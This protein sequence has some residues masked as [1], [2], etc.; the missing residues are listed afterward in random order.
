MAAESTLPTGT[1]KLD[2]SETTITV[3][4]KKLGMFTVPATLQMT[5]GALEIDDNHQVVNVDIVADAA[6]YASKSG[7]RNEHVVGSDFLDADAHP[8]LAFTASAVTP[9]TNG[10]RTSGSVTVK[11]QSSPVDV[12][13]DN[14]EITD[15]Q[16]S[17]TATAT[18]DR[19]AVGVDKM[20]TMMI[21]R[22]LQIMVSANA[23]RQG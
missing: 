22:D 5:S 3:S 2:P 10:Y 13:I 1:W 20:P 8:T 9:S 15:T 19:M 12:I 16:G 14:V 6:S 4:V 11:G 21:G 17:F 7:K 18:V 23:T